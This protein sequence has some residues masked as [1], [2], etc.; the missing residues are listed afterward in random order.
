MKMSDTGAEWPACKV[1]RIRYTQWSVYYTL[2]S[3]RTDSVYKVNKNLSSQI[4]QPTFGRSDFQEENLT[5][6]Y[7]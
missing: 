3:T 5:R 1:G 2:C 7:L 4:A 6:I